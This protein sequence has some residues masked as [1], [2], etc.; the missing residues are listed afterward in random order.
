MSLL[1]SG[2]PRPAGSKVETNTGVVRDDTL[3]HACY[4]HQEGVP[5]R[6]TMVWLVKLAHTRQ[7]C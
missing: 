2:G 7:F 4:M 3:L 6:F 5:G 1:T